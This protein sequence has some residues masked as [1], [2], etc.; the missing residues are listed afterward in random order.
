MFSK[1]KTGASQQFGRRELQTIPITGARTINAITKYNPLGDGSSFGAQDSRLNN[2][3]IDGSQFNNGFGL[4]SSA[5]AGGRTGSTAISLDAIDQLQVNIAPF[6]IRQSG[7]V[8]AGINAVTR[9]G[10]NEIEGSYYQTQ[11]DNSSRYVGNSAYGVPV[12]ASKFDEKVQGFR[13]GAPIIK[14]KLFIF[15]NYETLER[16]EPGTTWFSTGSPNAT[17]TQI[18]RPTSNLSI[19]ISYKQCWW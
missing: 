13:L 9:S 4:G 15:G 17:G 7:F 8:G 3:T 2:F 1:D 5:Q 14:D 12:T 19:S 11:R 18:S 10:T 16:T 6:D